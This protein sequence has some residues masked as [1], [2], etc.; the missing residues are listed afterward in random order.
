L[1]E[2]WSITKETV[3]NE[4]SQHPMPRKRREN[5]EEILNLACHVR[6]TVVVLQGVEGKGLSVRGLDAL[7]G[8]PV[9]DIEPCNPTYEQ[10]AGR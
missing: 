9:L 4:P 5:R 6:P 8:T 3:M 7:D 2:H 10:G 1:H